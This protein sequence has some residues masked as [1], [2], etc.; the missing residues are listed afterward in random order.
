LVLGEE[1]VDAF[2]FNYDRRESDLSYLNEASL[3]ALS[4]T[5]ALSLLAADNQASLI[6]EI[7]E[8]N[9]GTPL[10]R[11]FLWAALAFFL[12]EVLLL[13]FWKV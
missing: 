13:R 6:G 7:R 1:V 8:S 9:E 10:W 5:G 11:Y 3:E 2:A 4:A 12:V